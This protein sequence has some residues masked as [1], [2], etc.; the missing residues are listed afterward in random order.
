VPSKIEFQN[1]KRKVPNEDTKEVETPSTEKPKE[2]PVE[3]LASLAEGLVSVFFIMTFVA[4]TFA[5]PSGSMEKTLLIGDH[6]I[7][8]KEQFAP[9]AKWVGPLLPY[10]DLRHGDIAVFMSPEQPGLILVKRIIGLP[11]DH[12][13]LRHGEVYRNGDKLQEPYAQHTIGNDGTY[14]SAYRDNFPAVAPSMM[15]GVR[16]AKWRRE[17]P[18]HLQGEDIVVPPDSY[19]AMG[20]NRDNSYDSRYWGFLPKENLIGRPLFITWSF[21]SEEY[22]PEMSGAEQMRRTA[23][24]IVHFFD[25]TRWSRTL[26]LI[27]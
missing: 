25:K 8:N 2:T 17:M 20:D 24:V 13:H 11:G 10:R 6:L 21:E 16:N 4:Q 18:L 14:S 26:Q 1:G 7:V 5:I 22:G 3:F 15:A 19:F 12:L 9:A 23:D 27:R